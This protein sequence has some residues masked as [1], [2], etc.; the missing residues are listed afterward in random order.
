MRTPGQ[1]GTYGPGWLDGGRF[2]T[3]SVPTADLPASKCEWNRSLRVGV[4][5]GVNGVLDQR[6]LDQGDHRR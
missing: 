6:I 4:L 2:H 3:K 5:A 1:L